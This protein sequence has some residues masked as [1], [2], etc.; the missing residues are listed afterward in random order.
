MFDSAMTKARSITAERIIVRGL[1]QGVG[2][3]PT[4]WRLAKEH[5]IFGSVTNNGSGVEI[6]AQ[7]AEADVDAFITS[8]EREPP[9][10]ARIDSIVRESID[11]SDEF[12]DFHIAES[13]VTAVR[14]GVVPDLHPGH[15]RRRHGRPNRR[16]PGCRELR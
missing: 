3:R 6:L 4:V 15:Q 13:E 11:T 12:Q 5:N 16:C 1:V 8:L 10:L 7:A 14:T 2:F 9:A